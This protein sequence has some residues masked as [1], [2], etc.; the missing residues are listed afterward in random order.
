MTKYISKIA[1]GNNTLHIK[2]TE[3]RQQIVDSQV[4]KDFYFVTRDSTT[5]PS[6]SSFLHIERMSKGT[7]SLWV[8]ASGDYIWVAYP[9]EY[10]DKVFIV[11]GGLVVPMLAEQDITIEGKAFKVIRS[12]NTYSGYF[13]VGV[14]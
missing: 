5:M 6:I 12:K 14:Q 3:A 11:I 13:A 9:A 10:S 7:Y 8:G 1:K 2:D 4:I